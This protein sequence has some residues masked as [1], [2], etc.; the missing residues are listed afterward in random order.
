MSGKCV[1]VLSLLKQ[2]ILQ[3]GLREVHQSGTIKMVN[4]S[5]SVWLCEVFVL[6]WICDGQ[7]NAHICVEIK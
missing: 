7:V 1:G 5:I 2:Q 6:S 4:P 3:T